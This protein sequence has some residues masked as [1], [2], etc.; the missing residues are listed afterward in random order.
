MNQARLLPS[1][2]RREH[3]R[4]ACHPDRQEECRGM[5]QPCYKQ[6]LKVTPAEARVPTP[7]SSWAPKPKKIPNCHPDAQYGG[8]GLCKRCYIKAYRVV[9]LI[10]LKE[11]QQEKHFQVTYGIS[12]EQRNK[13][14]IAQSGLCAICARSMK[15]HGSGTHLD[16][17]HVTG[18]IRGLLCNTC[19]WFLSRID[20]DPTILDR[21][22]THRSTVWDK[23]DLAA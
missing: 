15:P 5:C 10:D 9:H 23:A 22:K 14:Y 16:H 3:T 13:I 2:K 4:S 7:R 8:N 12:V 21:I 19:N 6:W 18:V 1:K 20:A 11:K 17:C